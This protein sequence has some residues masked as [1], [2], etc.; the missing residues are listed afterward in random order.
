[1]K[2]KLKELLKEEWY[3]QGFPARPIFL[4]SACCIDSM[5]KDLGFS[6]HAIWMTYKEDYCEFNYSKTDLTAHAEKIVQ[7]LVKDPGYLQK[8][9]ELNEETVE[10][11]LPLI[12]NPHPDYSS[13][14]D[15]AL[16]GLVSKMAASIEGVIGGS[17]M[18][19]S[20]SLRLE[21][22]IRHRL[23]KQ[24]S[25]KELNE[26][27]SVL[28]APTTQSF[29]SKKE[30]GLWK[31][32]QAK[33][34]EKEK[35]VEKFWNDFCWVN[36]SYVGN[37]PWTRETIIEEAEKIGSFEK[38]DFRELQKKKLELFK[39]Y[40][41][42]E[43]EQQWFFWTEFLTD[44]QDNRKKNIFKAIFAFEQ[45]LAELSRRFKIDRKYLHYLLSDD[46]SIES[47]SD[48][49][50]KKKAEFRM[51]GSVFVRELGKLSVFEGE[52]F[53]EF[54]KTF[55]HVHEDVSILTGMAASLGIA[56][57]PVKICTTIESLSKVQQGDILVASMTRPEY[58]S[59]M[60]KA[61]AIVT[62]EGGVTCHAAIVSR[63]LGIP[64]V[65]GTQ[66]ATKVLKDGWIVQVNA[67]HSSITV[68]DK[69]S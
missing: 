40:H 60:K 17:H 50:A 12:E 48:G 52:E 10:K 13:T 8:K 22:N 47:L 25:G 24:T 61:A 11:W 58:V 26:D 33:G 65:I 34:K 28:T 18:I 5:Q 16:V 20:V 36:S 6:Y 3:T 2:P 57:G 63:E 56:T 69:G 7:N 23:S 37:T 27:F 55:E 1:M 21:R 30:E 67:N 59:A 62:D 43:E 19:E 35:A 14:S 53:S 29:L 46:I 44:W 9:R 45:V 32:K 64:C 39:K 42:T 31:I 38:P 68:I 15:E 41:L 4:V 66:K 49:S 51:K 54:K